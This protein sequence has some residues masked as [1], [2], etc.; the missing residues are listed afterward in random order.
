MEQKFI[1]N[2]EEIT[3]VEKEKTLFEYGFSLP[4]GYVKVLVTEAPKDSNGEE[5][6]NIYIIDEHFRQEPLN[7]CRLQEPRECITD[8]HKYFSEKWAEFQAIEHYLWFKYGN[9]DKDTV[10]SYSIEQHE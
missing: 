2:E 10:Y 1:K 6:F 3:G 9:P 4:M 7:C 5:Y 8:P